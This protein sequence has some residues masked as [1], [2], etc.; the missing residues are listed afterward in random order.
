[1]IRRYI[2]YL[3]AVIGFQFLAQEKEPKFQLNG[4]IKEL[5]EFSF[6]DQLQQLEYNGLLHNR[7]NFKYLPSE[8]ILVRLEMR[9]RIFYGSSVR[10]IVG[11]SALIQQDNGMVDLNWNLVD[12]GNILF[13]TTID[14]ALVNYT[15]EDWVI[16]VGRQRINWGMNLVWNP[17]DIFNTYNILDFDYEERPGCDAVRVQYYVNDFSKIEVAAK[18]GRSAEDQIVVALYKFNQWSYDI[19]FLSGVY[20]KDWVVGVGWAGNLKDMGFKGEVSYFVPY[21][22]Y[23]NS[24]NV[25][26]AS[27]SG[28]YAFKNGWFVNGSLLYNSGAR[29]RN[30]GVTDLFYYTLSAKNLMPFEYS[31]YLQFAREFTPI[32]RGN[33]GAIYSPTRDSVIV[34]PGLDYSIATNWELSFIGQSFFEFEDYKSLGHSL[35]LRA[36]WSF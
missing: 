26:S 13:N 18:K 35:F 19:Q 2:T 3:M 34:M 29:N 14:R 25:W 23:V 10:D 33:F 32:F 15:H 30:L 5:N 27:V 6:T 8:E 24:E 31:T 1:M 28:D 22:T 9:N 20:R 36:R 17:N 21:E 4:Y 16:T 7:L 12:D 11:F